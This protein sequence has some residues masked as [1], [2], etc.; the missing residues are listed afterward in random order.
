MNSLPLHFEYLLSNM[1]FATE[2]YSRD[3]N[4]MEVNSSWRELYRYT[5]D[6]IPDINIFTNN[7]IIKTGVMDKLRLL[8][9]NGGK[10]KTVP[11][12]YE[13]GD[14][15]FTSVQKEM[16]FKFYF[17]SIHDDDGNLQYIINLIEEVTDEI[18]QSEVQK[19]LEIQKR[20]SKIILDI[21]EGERKRL[22]QELHDVVGQKIL[23]AKLNIELFKKKH[24]GKIEELDE[25]IK[26]L[27]DISKEIKSVIHSLHPIVI[28]KYGVIDSLDLLVHEF[29]MSSGYEAIIK[30]FG[31][32]E[33]D[34]IN[35]DLN[36]YRIVQESLNN[37]AKH[38]NA[39][40]VEI[41]V[42]FTDTL[43]ICSVQDDGVGF[44]YKETLSGMP[45]KY[46]YGLI[47][48]KERANSLGGELN[49]DTQTG[50]GTKIVF[51]I[52]TGKK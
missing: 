33:Y 9:E 8:F 13:K 25:S 24:D 43:V 19:E 41:E 40:N 30:Y 51:Q 36:I 26:Q 32:P 5:K 21:L 4:L 14:L 22:A 45:K 42:H 52:P 39:K 31:N 6:S 35:I 7:L 49:V 17:Y 12:L 34:D 37:I 38:S 20:N 23:L 28:E 16:V 29:N 3:G 44:N 15:N 11:V 1:P 10:L 27:I 48:M 18:K 50:K 47:S 46:N 2:I